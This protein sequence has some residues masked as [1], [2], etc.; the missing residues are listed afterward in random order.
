MSRVNRVERIGSE[1]KLSISS[2]SK[3][4]S[5][6]RSVRVSAALEIN[7]SN[8]GFQAEGSWSSSSDSI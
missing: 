8:V 1:S 2:D 5:M 4:W 3:I 7:R 6:V